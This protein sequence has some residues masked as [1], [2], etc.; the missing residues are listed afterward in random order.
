[1]NFIT[2]VRKLYFPGAPS[3]ELTPTDIQQIL[4]M[5]RF[6]ECMLGDAKFR[7]DFYAFPQQRVE[8][9]EARGVRNL[10]PDQLAVMIPEDNFITLD[11]IDADAYPL[12]RLWRRWIEATSGFRSESIK[13]A[14]Q[15]SDKDY[16]LWRQRQISRCKSQ[17][18]SNMNDGLVHALFAIE[19]NKGCSMK[20]PFC[21]IAAP[22]LEDTFTYTPE[23]AQLLRE[24]VQVFQS[25]FGTA[26][27]SG[28]CYWATDPADNPDYIRFAKD[29]GDITGV[30]PQATTAAP[31]RD[32]EWTKA[33]IEFRKNHLCTLDRFSILSAT[34][35][36]QVHER[37]SPEEL[38]FVEMV[39]VNNDSLQPR[40]RTGR[41]IDPKPRKTRGAKDK[42]SVAQT[43]EGTIACLS[44]FLINMVDRSIKLISPRHAS[45]RYPLG[46][47]VFA[48]SHFVTA[49]D[50]EQ[51]IQDMTTHH[52]KRK[53]DLD[54]VFTFRSDLDY[55]PR[56]DGF[57]LRNSYFVHKF[58]DEPYMVKL[59]QLANKGTMTGSEVLA[60]L[61][62]SHSNVFSVSAAFQD[63]F[64]RGLLEDDF[65]VDVQSIKLIPA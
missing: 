33:M 3:E 18:G 60:E 42:K 43:H 56:E 15:S 28:F 38:A 39:C 11:D 27:G 59:G 20:C 65:E 64:D 45:N 53:L 54:D 10:D 2:A 44:G 6:L 46:Y 47:R 13:R 17:L 30:Y 52:M 16:Q 48:E 31:M 24:V 51:I 58:T 62:Q 35:L 8:L 5:K 12:I 25:R 22:P 19:L 7:E 14:G 1:M 29:V 40:T 32:V 37:F 50:V 34:T 55:V 26:A 4:H 36:R 49:Q 61:L 9:L 21:G 57:H 63:L 23:N 41:N